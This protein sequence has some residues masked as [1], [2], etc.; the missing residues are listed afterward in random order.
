MATYPLLKVVLLGDG[1]VGKT[2]LARR[3]CE[4]MFEESRIMTIGVDFQTKVVGMPEGTVKLSIWDVAG[5]PHFKVVREGFYRGS[6]SAALVY[7]MTQPS[8]LANLLGWIEEVQQYAPNVKFAVIGNK[9]DLV[10]PG[11]SVGGEE[12]AHSLGVPH[13]LTSAKD[14]LG[15]EQMFVDLARLA[16]NLPLDVTYND[17]GG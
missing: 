3:Y 12:F 4:G 9:V 14:G 11:T 15:V 6:L 13:L 7:D 8:T 16:V 10:P 5:Q 17:G 1:N 2:S